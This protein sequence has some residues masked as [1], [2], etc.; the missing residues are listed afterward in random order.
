MGAFVYRLELEDG[1]PADPAHAPH[2]RSRLPLRRC[3]PAGCQ[4][5]ACGRRQRRRLRP[6]AGPGGRRHARAARPRG[7]SQPARS[8]ATA[9]SVPAQPIRAT[10]DT[11]VG[12]APLP[13]V[14]AARM[15][16]MP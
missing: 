10:S 9:S 16:A 15:P 11:H 5:A 3:D 6:G 4:D 14:C 1:T 13:G 12:M 2:G 7:S 8:Q